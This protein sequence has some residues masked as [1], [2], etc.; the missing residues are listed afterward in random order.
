MKRIYTLLISLLVLTTSASLAQQATAILFQPNPGSTNSL[1]INW[2]NG[3]GVGRIVVVKNSSGGWIPVNGANITTLNANVS[4][5]A[6]TNDQDPGSGVAAVVFAGTGSGP[7]TVSNLSSGISYFVQVYEFTG[8]TASPVYVLTSNS[9]NPKGFSFYTSNGSFTTPVDVTTVTA[10]AWGGGAGAGGNTQSSG[11]SNNGGG[12]GAYASD[13]LTGLSGAYSITVGTG[14]T[15]SGAQ[16]GTGVA[17]GA[18]SFGVLLSANGGSGGGPGDTQGGAGGTVGTASIK[19]AGGAGGSRTTGGNNG[20]GGGG[21][22]AGTLGNGGNGGNA[23][24]STGGAAGSAGSGGGAT[25]GSGGDDTL[26]GNNG[27]FPGGGGG[28]RGTNGVTPGNGAGGLIIVSYN[29][30]TAPTATITRLLPNNRYFNA[31]TTTITFRVTFNEDVTNVDATDFVT[32]GFTAVGT[33]G[34]VSANPGGQ[35]KTYDVQVNTLSGQGDYDLNFAAGQNIVDLSNNAFSGTTSGDQIYTRDVSSPTSFMVGSLTSVGGTVVPTYWNSTNTTLQVVVPLDNADGSLDGGSIQLQI[36]NNTNAG[37]V[38]IPTSG[39]YT[40]TNTDRTNGTVTI[41]V[42]AANLSAAFSGATG[43]QNNDAHTIRARVTDVT[44]NTA[45]NYTASATTLNVDTTPPAIPAAPDLIAAS[46]SNITTDNITNGNTPTFDVTGNAGFKLEILEGSNIIAFTNSATGALEQL[47]VSSP[48]SDNSSYSITARVYD[49][50][51]NTAISVAMSPVLQIDTNPPATPSVPDLQNASD[52]GVSNSDN[53]TN[54]TTP[55]F[56]VT[57]TSGI[58]LELMEGATVLQTI[59]SANGSPQAMTSASL[60]PNASHVIFARSTDVAGNSTSSAN[61]TINLD[62]TN[63][64]LTSLTPAQNPSKGIIIRTGTI[65]SSTGNPIVTGSS[66]QFTTELFVGAILRSATNQAIGTI[67]TIDSDTQVTLTGNA[68]TTLGS[69]T[70]YGQVLYFT[71]TFDGPMTTSTVTAADFAEV[72][73]GTLGTVVP[74]TPTPS[75]TSQS[76]YIHDTSFGTNGS[77]V[78]NWNA[79][80]VNDAAGNTSSAGGSGTSATIDNTAPTVTSIVRTTPANAFT[81]ATSVTFTVTFSESVTGVDA[82]D[83][84]KTVTGGGFSAGGITVTQ[85]SGTVYTVD[86]ASITAVNGTLRLDVNANT[87]IFDATGNQFGTIYNSGQIYT[88]DYTPPVAPAAFSA[89]TTGGNVVANYWNTH[90]TGI[91]LSIT[92]PNSADLLNG[93]VEVEAGTVAGG[94][95]APIALIPATPNL[96]SGINATKLVSMDL[97]AIMGIAGYADGQQLRFRVRIVDQAGNNGA[98]AVSSNNLTVDLI[99]PTITGTPSY[100]PS[101]GGGGKETITI[102]FSETI[103]LANN[104]NPVTTTT[105]GNPGFYSAQPQINVGGGTKYLSA[106]NTIVLESNADGDWISPVNLTYTSN[107]GVSGNYVR[108]IAGNELATV[109]PTTNAPPPVLASSMVLDPNDAGNEIITFTVDVPLNTPT[110]ANAVTGITVDADGTGPGAAVS[111]AGTYTAAGNVITL[112]SSAANEWS[113]AT[114]VSYAAGNLAS[115]GGTPMATFGPEPILLGPV[116]ISSSNTNNTVAKENDVITVSF[117]RAATSTAFTATPTVTFNGPT[118]LSGVTVT[119]IDVTDPTYSFSVTPNASVTTDGFVTFSIVALQSGRSTTITKTLDGSSVTYDRTPPATPS[120]PDLAAGSDSNINTDN[121]TN[122]NSG[123]V[124]QG[125]NGTVENN[126]TVL[127]YDNASLLGT[128]TATATGSWTYTHAGTLADGNHPITIVA[129]DAAGNL[130]TASS[131]LKVRIDTQ[132]PATLIQSVQVIAPPATNGSLTDGVN[133]DVATDLT[134]KVVFKEGVTGL[135]NSNFVVST[136]TNSSLTNTGKNVVAVNDSI[137]LVT[138]TSVKG[139]GTITVD[140]KN[141]SSITDLAGNVP[142]GSDFNTPF[143][144]GSHNFYSMVYPEPSTP[145]ASF[146]FNAKTTT[147]INVRINHGSG[148]QLPTHYLVMAKE[149]LLTSV[150]F[151]SANDKIPVADDFT[152]AD[153]LLAQNVVRA[154]LASQIVSFTG[155]KSGVEYDF[156]VYPYTISDASPKNYTD[157]NINF[158]TPTSITTPGITTNV[159][160]TTTIAGSGSGTIKSFINTAGTAQNVFTIDIQ[161]NG[162]TPGADNAPFKFNGLTINNQNGTNWATIIAGAELYDISSPSTFVSASGANI[163]ATQITFPTIPT[164]V[165]ALGYVANDALKSYGLRIY[166]KT[167]AGALTGFDNA[168]LA[169]SVNDLSFALDNGAGT[170]TDHQASSTIVPSSTATSGITTLQID[171]TKLVFITNPIAQIGVN[172]TFPV[173][174]VVHALDANNNIDKDFT[175]ATTFSI[176]PASATYSTTFTAGVLTLSDFV[177]KQAGTANI[178]VSSAGV[179]SATSDS[180]NVTAGNQQTTAVISGLTQITASAALTEPATVSSLVNTNLSAVN[181]FDFRISDDVGAV[182]AN[183]DGLPTLIRNLRISRNA[184]NGTDNTTDTDG[185]DDWTKSIAGAELTD[186]TTSITGSVSA[187]SITFSS[188]LS[189]SPISSD[190]GFIGDDGFKTYTLKIWLNNSIGAPLSQSIDLKDFVFEMNDAGIDLPLTSNTSSTIANS[191]TNSGNNNNKVD[192]KATALVFSTEPAATQKY[193]VNLSVTP[194]VKAQDSNGNLDLGYNSSA[195]LSAVFVPTIPNPTAN[196]YPLSTTSFTFINGVVNL[197][198]VTVQSSGLG[199]NGDNI[200]LKLDDT[201]NDPLVSSVLSSTTIVMSYDGASDIIKDTSLPYGQN[202]LYATPANQASPITLND[203]STGVRLER[204]QVRDG[205]G[206]TD[207]DGTGTSLSAVT[208][209]VTNYQFLKRLALFDAGTNTLLKEVDVALVAAN[210]SGNAADIPFSGITGFTAPD[211]GVRSFDVVGTFNSAV[212]AGLDNSVISFAIKSVSPSP[213]SSTFTN[214]NPVGIVSTQ[215]GNQNKIEVKATTIVFTTVPTVARIGEP[216]AVVVSA[217]DALGNLDTDYNGAV[218][219]PTNTI[220]GSF[221]TINNPSSASFAGGTYTY[222]PLFQ[223]NIG[224]GNVSLK[225]D[226]GAGNAGS[227]NDDAGPFLANTSPIINVITSFDSWLYLDPTFTYTP[228]ID[229][230]NKRESSLTS[231]SQSLALFV[232]SDGGAPLSGFNLIT[233]PNPGLRTQTIHQDSDK[234]G[235]SISSLS[236]SISNALSIQKIALFDNANNKIGEQP[237]ASI[238]TFTGLNTANLTA[239]DD[240]V[241]RFYIRASFVDNVI[242]QTPINIQVNSVTW[243]AGSQ[244]PNNGTIGGV[245]GGEATP[246]SGVNLLNVIATSLDFTTQPSAFAGVNEPIIPTNNGGATA[247]VKARD[248]FTNLDTGFNF[249]YT[250][251]APKGGIAFVPAAF[252]AGILDLTGMQYS[253]TGTGATTNGNGTLTV[254]ANGINSNTNSSSNSKPCNRVDVI[255]VGAIYNGNSVAS[256]NLKGGTTAIIFGASISP[257][258]FTSTLQGDLTNEPAITSLSFSFDVGYQTTSATTFTNFYVYESTNGLFSGSTLVTNIGG[259]ITKLKSAGAP[260]TTIYDLVNVTFATPRPLY[261][262]SGQPSTTKTYFLVADISNTAT[263]NTPKITPRLIDNGYPDNSIGVTQGSAKANVIAPKA[264]SFASTNP[265]SLVGSQ[266]VPFSGQLNVNPNIVSTGIDLVFDVPVLTLDGNAELWERGVSPNADTKISDLKATTGKFVSIIGTPPTLSTFTTNP[267]HFNFVTAVTL[268]PDRVY[269]VKI[270]QG[271]YDPTANNGGGAGTGISDDQT[272]LYGGISYNGTMYFKIVSNYPPKMVDT[273][274]AKYDVS[275]TVAVLNASFD[276]KGKAYYLILDNAKYIGSPTASDI[277]GPTSFDTNNFGAVIKRGS[278][279]ITQLSPNAQYFSVAGNWNPGITYDVW[280]YAQNDALPNPFNSLATSKPYGKFIAPNNANNFIIG[281]AGPTFSFTEPLNA[282]TPI[283]QICPNSYT[284]LSQPIVITESASNKWVVGNQDFNLLLPTGF[285]FDVKSIP[286]ITLVGADFSATAP[287]F[288][289]INS[290]ILKVGFSISTLTN[291]DKIVIS[292]L[293]VIPNSTSASGDIV[294]FGGTGLAGIA[295]LTKFATISANSLAPQAFTNSYTIY[296]DFVSSIKLSNVVTSIPDNYLDQ[297][298]SKGNEIK[299]I[300]TITPAN[301]FNASFFSGTGVSDDKLSLSSIAKNAAFNV[302]MTHTDL[303]GCF[304]SQKSQYLV[305]DHTKIIPVLTNPTY[306]PKQSLVNANF[307]K[308][309]DVTNFSTPAT[310]S[311]LSPATLSNGDIAGYKLDSMVLR[312]P[313]EATASSQIIFGNAWQSQL[314]KVLKIVNTTSG[315][316]PYRDYKWDYAHVLNAKSESGGAVTMNPYDNFI[317]KTPSNSSNYKGGNQ[318]Y[319][320]GGSLGFVD[321]IGRFQSQADFT[322]IQPLVQRI[323]LFVP[324]IPI[325]EVVGQS[326]VIAGSGTSPDIYVFCEL[327]SDIVFQGYPAASPGKSTASYKLYDDVSNTLLTG[328]GFTDNANSNGTATLKPNSASYKNGNNTIRVE[329]TYQDNN[330]PSVGIGKF[331]IQIAPNPVA[332]FTFTSTGPNAPNASN[333]NAICVNN[334]IKFTPNVRSPQ[335]KYVWNFADGSANYTDTIPPVHQYNKSLTY[336]ASLSFISDKN[337][338]SIPTVGATVVAPTVK[339]VVVGDLPIVDFSFL[340]NCVGSVISFTD[341]SK[342]PT[343]GNSLPFKADWDFGDGTT[344]IGSS[345]GSTSTNTYGTAK[346]YNVI[347]TSTTDLGCKDSGSKY[348]GQL[349]KFSPSQLASFDEK[350]D[351]A[352]N[353]PV[354][355]GWITLDINSVNSVPKPSAPISTGISSWMYDASNGNWTTSAS[356]QKNEKSALYSAC[357]DLSTIPRPVISFDATVKL[358]DGESIVLQYSTD[359]LNIQDPAKN[360]QVL[361]T[362][363]T[364]NSPGLDWYNLSALAS[365]PGTGYANSQNPTALGWATDLGAIK[366]KHKLEDVGANSEVILRFAFSSI[367]SGGNGTTNGVTIDNI[368]VGSRTRTVLFEN[369]TTTD[370]GSTSS[371]L[372]QTLKDEATYITNFTNANINSTQ[373]VNINYHIGFIGND[374]FNALNPADPSSRALYYNVTQA[375]YAFLDGKHSSNNNSDLFQN[376]GQGAYDLQ[377]LNLANADFKVAGIPTKVTTNNSNGTIE[378]EVN[379]TPTKDLP[380]STRLFIGVLEDQV[381]KTQIPGTPSITTGETDFNYVLRKMLPNAVGTRYPDGTFKRDQQVRLGP[382][383][384]IDTNADKFTWNVDKVFGSKL[385]VVVFLQDSTKEVYQADLFQ[386]VAIP[387]L[388]TGLEPL[389]AESI[390]L[391]PNPANQEFTI[392]LPKALSVDANVSLVDQMGRTIDGGL[393]SAGRTKKTVGTYDLAA[394]V[395]IVQI[396]TDGG[397]TVR[398][399]VVIVH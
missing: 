288:S 335:Y 31:S 149:S 361:G 218:S 352:N 200:K 132:A 48:M 102:N 304:L 22:S 202:I 264:F 155:L 166:F 184:L 26:V 341:K 316:T 229:F 270:P 185:F 178:V 385:T 377:T 13:V 52:T 359:N 241:I 96:I 356:Y 64:T 247:V 358:N 317:Q 2:T 379:V 100:N 315:G 198:S 372:N 349:L 159:A 244:F 327:G 8:T 112:N 85:V 221:N 76:F 25:G 309:S 342:T 295:D 226:C 181:N 227:G 254:I 169:F 3:T 389:N 176:L 6:G 68:G 93:S 230:I 328:A 219:N 332:D 122:I 160:N 199:I 14:G 256:G 153:G 345:A 163:T 395:Y 294:R 27:T 285:D 152:A 131:Q 207:T 43:Y 157:D 220:P 374:P 363:P 196:A 393:I 272:N 210:V 135:A 113:S 18:S 50:A 179:T 273:D 53:L 32:T 86:V 203:G 354:D 4:F 289:F 161:D 99:V 373:L 248:K 89:V 46:D 88:F 41:S 39:L 186:G 237:G 337:C 383:G 357:L 121:Y 300:P 355:G 5:T 287:T 234:A 249:G 278:F 391:Y 190:I 82:A 252:T 65:S 193:D 58:K 162:L 120:I 212:V 130:S 246:T 17:G 109:S 320:L 87:S 240:G 107:V 170:D 336:L 265:P 177:F 255:D 275:S 281:G 368:R 129:S 216:F 16:N 36:Q 94:S 103:A 267:I 158:G 305:Y 348:I 319:Y 333:A 286:T 303:N 306:G 192:V 233:N 214:P 60:T 313:K 223:F 126:A 258:Y 284:T 189:V 29:D 174:P 106:S 9:T 168:S 71:A 38:N 21:G 205:G 330:S 211:N 208:I 276:Q 369:F 137:Y 140:F 1:T 118:G 69:G 47:T 116:T 347:L 224:N 45:T 297:L 195:T 145:V 381:I 110:G 323:E 63:P 56:D 318:D 213:V 91:D 188:M 156:V 171:A 133:G 291:I 12:G 81:K 266:C 376:W 123:L 101:G 390:N 78:I 394:G 398:K 164:T 24:T 11:G 280:I 209:R 187:N 399:K 296:N 57:G 310:P 136:G 67:L 311:Q 238:V 308:P 77:S 236:L 299:L 124:F 167:A 243:A 338:L 353:K 90:N 215:T 367:G 75:L 20:G 279:D 105:N 49:V 139:T 201:P 28:G 206:A 344:K 250:I 298:Y 111:V 366:P 301:D 225:V 257:S 329:Y 228:Q 84:A 114:T 148:A 251:S 396:K 40:I 260:V 165:G 127:V 73:V 183:D 95:F 231:T 380:K 290:T 384:K 80:A 10:Q 42:S 283:Y 117:T 334:E 339:S 51:G 175:S 293:R 54:V 97:V 326:T 253:S 382:N 269:Y 34:T 62:N 277:N 151:Y 268:L 350:F 321:F 392:E 364:G 194:Q 274:L 37:Y 324:P 98:F 204:F 197:S 74:A 7:V 141:F 143:T 282:G 362:L 375:P 371:S 147:S 180:D 55:I 322:V 232:L 138:V 262:T 340:G 370:A 263:S 302:T 125:I 146:T 343:G 72:G 30:N 388:T 35:L 360:W 15:G 235:T 119:P 292:D 387:T 378:V 182:T 150:N 239:P 307:N 144:V 325:I 134:F 79:T 128:T 331:Y 59:A 142:T 115:S 242:D 397:E 172:K 66:T 173:A 314:N 61:I 271:T 351:G 70:S 23:V 191:N 154:G 245:A 312:I 217:Q 44:G 92:I 104:A 365:N 259:T 346:S 222:P 108:D 19:F 83:F 386:N 261:T 33:I